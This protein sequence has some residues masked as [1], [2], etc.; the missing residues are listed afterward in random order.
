MTIA[1]SISGPIAGSIGAAITDPPVGGGVN[2]ASLFTAEMGWFYDTSDLSTLF[3]DAEG[4]TPATVNGLVGRQNDKSPR[5]LHRTQTTTGSKPVLRGSPTGSNLFTAYG[6]PGAGWVDSGG[7]V[8]TATAS[9][10]AM[11]TTTAA[12]IG[13]VYRV[14]YTMTRTA[15]TLTPSFGGVSLTAQSAAGTYEQ[16]ITAT[17]TAVLTFT[18]SSYSGAVSAI[19]TFDVSAGSVQAP[20]FLQYDGVDDFLVT[21]SANFTATD[22]VTVVAGLRKIN[23]F[24]SSGVYV[25]LTASMDTN[26]QSFA[27]IAPVTAGIHYRFGSRGSAASAYA[28][29]P[30]AGF[31]GGHTS[32]TTGIGDI[33]GDSM[34]LRINGKQEG[35]LASDQGTGNYAN[36]FVYFG[37]RGALTSAFN[38]YDY[39]SLGIGK[40]LSAGDLSNVERFYASRTGVTLL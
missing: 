6:T 10:A 9:N 17:S 2:P 24:F 21:A 33:A 3:E 25:E 4:T 12:V 28:G 7:G 39:G 27:L 16:H 36:A 8:A 22:K 23:Q 11:P 5:G 30:S 18:G 37:R 34:I 26:A 29:T 40:L 19:E 32:V 38:G 20:Y 14:K 15:G 31:A 13:K 1:T 35:S